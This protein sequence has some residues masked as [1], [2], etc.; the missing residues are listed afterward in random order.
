MDVNARISIRNAGRRIEPI[1]T[2]GAV[3][4]YRQEVNVVEDLSDMLA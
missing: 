2:L 4:K 3:N 1:A